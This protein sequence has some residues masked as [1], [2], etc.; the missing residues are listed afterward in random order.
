MRLAGTH[1]KMYVYTQKERLPKE[2]SPRYRSANAFDHSYEYSSH[3]EFLSNLTFELSNLTYK[4][5]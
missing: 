2:A 5:S 3:G 1:T 4:C